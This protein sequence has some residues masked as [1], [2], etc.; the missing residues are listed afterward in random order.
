MRAEINVCQVLGFRDIKKSAGIQVKMVTKWGSKAISLS[1]VVSEACTDPSVYPSVC[2]PE[3]AS[4][5]F[6]QEN[7]GTKESC[8]II[9][10][11]E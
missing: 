3:Y 4:Q 2:T 9:I 10:E 5:G 6:L 1:I 7:V 11:E 8:F